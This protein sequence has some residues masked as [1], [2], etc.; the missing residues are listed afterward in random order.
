MAM[1]GYSMTNGELLTEN[2]TVRLTKEDLEVLVETCKNRR[3][4]IGAFVR[5]AAL[6]RLGRLG[7]LSKEQMTALGVATDQQ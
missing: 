1:V 6:Q 4:A 7:T 2:V 3:E 5:V